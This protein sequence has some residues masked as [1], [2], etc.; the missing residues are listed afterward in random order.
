MQ[1]HRSRLCIVTHKIAFHKVHILLWY[2]YCVHCHTLLEQITM[3]L[4]ICIYLNSYNLATL[5][6]GYHHGASC[7]VYLRAGTYMVKS[8]VSDWPQE[9]D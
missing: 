7:G 5:L 9:S 1:T 6:L 4:Y 8:F 2:Q 3:L